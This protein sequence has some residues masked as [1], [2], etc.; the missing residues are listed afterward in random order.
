MSERRSYS[1]APLTEWLQF[2]ERVLALC[3]QIVSTAQIPD[4]VKG[5]V[6]HRLLG[7]ALICRTRGNYRG[8]AVLAKE[9]LVTEA[10][11]LAR[12]CFENLIW[13]VGLVEGKDRFVKEILDDQAKNSKSRM[14][15][16]SKDGL[17]QTTLNMLKQLEANVDFI[18]KRR[19]KAKMIKLEYVA[20]KFMKRA[21]LSY[22]QLS[23]D[24]AHA[25]FVAMKR[26]I[27]RN[28]DGYAIVQDPS[29]FNG[30]RSRQS[31]GPCF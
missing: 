24:S 14:S 25:S 27:H 11:T 4:G 6:D 30:H 23:A 13:T 19:P 9:G 28:D 26:H 16:V 20:S 1:G 29:E 8:T 17:D 15:V 3:T 18:M 10:R 21:Y 12:S 5:L 7:L 2:S 22:R 31:C